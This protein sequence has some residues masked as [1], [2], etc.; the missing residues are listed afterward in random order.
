[1]GVPMDLSSVGDAL[2]NP[3]YT[4]ENRCLP[5]T[6][7]NGLIAVGA[8]ATILSVTGQPALAL[9]TLS[10]SFLLIALRGYLVPGTPT[11]TKRYFPDWFLRWVETG[12]VTGQAR[13]AVEGVPDSGPASDSTSALRDVG[14]LEP[15]P[16]GTDDCLTDAFETAWRE[17]RDTI[18]QDAYADHLG[19]LLGRPADAL[20]VRAF[21]ADAHGHAV[22]V[23]HDETVVATWES[24]AALLADV[25]TARALAARDPAWEETTLADKGHLLSGVRLFL[26]RCPACDGDVRLSEEPVESCCRTAAVVTLSCD[27]CDA[28]LLEVEI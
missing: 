18:Q 8:S 3:A 14:V 26:E 9:A 4:G 25:A 12:A 28:R 13:P 20:E 19:A 10:G 1:M 7:T 6:L 23:V 27:H 17:Q 22:V 2:R 5:C 11:L 21:A 24:E 16:D 15:A